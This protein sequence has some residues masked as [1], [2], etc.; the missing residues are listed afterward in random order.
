MKGKFIEDTA[1]VFM[2]AVM[3]YTCKEMLRF[4]GDVTTAVNS[5]CITRSDLKFVVECDD[6]IR[7]YIKGPNEEPPEV[8]ST[9]A[10]GVA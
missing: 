9:L 4:A 6:E 5:S 10:Q 1:A 2:S 3:Q 8:S 7:E